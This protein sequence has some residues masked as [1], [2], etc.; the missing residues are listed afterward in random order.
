MLRTLLELGYDPVEVV[1]ST[2]FTGKRIAFHGS[3]KTMDRTELAQRAV[4]AG[5][6]VVLS[7]TK[8]TDYLVA[9]EDRGQDSQKVRT[10]RHFGIPIITEEDFIQ[11]SS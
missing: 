7:V 10:A 2:P 8:A 3:F 11:M 9:G 6:H 4:A 5:A 1:A